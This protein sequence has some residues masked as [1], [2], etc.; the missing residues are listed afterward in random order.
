MTS[1]LMFDV[2]NNNFNG[3]KKDFMT[4]DQAFNL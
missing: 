3:K 1:K 2:F 4:S